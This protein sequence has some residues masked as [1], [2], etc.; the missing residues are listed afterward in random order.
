MIKLIVGNKGSGKTKAL[1]DM[2]NKTTATS[3]GYV[4]CIENGLK[5]TYDIDHKAR[6][7]DTEHYGLKGYPALYGFISGVMSG[8][9]D[10]TDLFIDQTFKIAGNDMNE[11]ERLVKTLVPLAEE[12]NVNL[13]LTVSA[14]EKDL[15]ADLKQYSVKY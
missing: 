11:F 7:I 4:V 10:I 12:N 9:Y 15:P 5:L 13:V 3:K 2:V 8:N 14:D 1:I 6:L